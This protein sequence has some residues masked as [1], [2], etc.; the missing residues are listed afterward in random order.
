M[1]KQ[2]LTCQQAQPVPPYEASQMA[3]AVGV[4][5]ASFLFPLVVQLDAVLDKRY[6]RCWWWRIRTSLLTA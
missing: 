6:C 2:Y 4:Q 1:Q 5:L 3:Q